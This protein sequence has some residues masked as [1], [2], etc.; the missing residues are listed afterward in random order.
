MHTLLLTLL[1]CSFVDAL[2]SIP[3]SAPAPAPAPQL[4]PSPSPSPSPARERQGNRG[5]AVERDDGDAVQLEVEGAPRTYRVV[6]PDGYTADRAW[7]L[8]IGFHGGGEDANG[9]KM[10]PARVRELADGRPYTGRQA[11]K[12]G[13]IDAIGGEDDARAWL[14]AE[15]AV[16]V[17]LPVQELRALGLRERVLGDGTESI[18]E[19]FVK[20]LL[21]Q[22]VSLDGAWSVWQVL[23]T[24][25]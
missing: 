2:G 10:D 11:L 19:G 7:P 23:A 16:P 21:S 9:R 13:L 17:S 3:T 6:P 5:A 8:V 20:I 12:L 4:S 22:R 1:G 25:P 15:R 14:A 24:R 18:F